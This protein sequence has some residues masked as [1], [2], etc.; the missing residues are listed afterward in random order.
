MEWRMCNICSCTICYIAIGAHN[1]QMF[2]EDACFAN[3]VAPSNLPL[4]GSFYY[5][6]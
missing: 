1:T 5:P 2:G 4:D 6:F 3:E